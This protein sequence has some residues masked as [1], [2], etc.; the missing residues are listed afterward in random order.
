VVTEISFPNP[1]PQYDFDRD[2][3]IFRALAG[4]K[5]V[6][7]IVTG[8]L[9]VTHF[10]APDMTEESLLDAYRRHRGNIQDIARNHIEN[11]WVEEEGRL[12]LT[13]YYTRLRVSFGKGLLEWAAGRQ[14]AE[15]AHTMLLEIIGPNAETVEVEWSGAGDLPERR[16]IQ[17]RILDPDVAHS[18]GMSLRPQEWDNLT[19]L[20][21]QLAGAWSSILRARSHKLSLRSG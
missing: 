8:K 2:V 5:Q 21:F 4:E 19:F 7:C 11:R 12:F 18:T 17:L 15:Q 3:L 20:R 10:G 6:E 13:T 16:F 1:E 9:L 14:L